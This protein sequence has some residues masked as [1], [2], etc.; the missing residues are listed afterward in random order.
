M[1]TPATPPS[2]DDEAARIGWRALGW[3]VLPPLAVL[4]LQALLPAD[5]EGGALQR[6]EGATLVSD[7]GQALWMASR[8]LVYGLLAVGGAAALLVALVR[9]LGW[10]RA[11]PV[12]LALWVLLW[13]ATGAWLVAGDQNCTQREALPEQPVKVLLAR[14]ILPSKRK[15]PGG[16]EVYFELPGESEPMRLFAQG[17]PPAAF[18]PGSTALLHSEAGRWWGRWGRLR[19]R[20]APPAT[21]AT[22]PASTAPGG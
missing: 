14:E 11:R 18:V 5:V 3:L 6:L 9:R 19:S 1:N 22:P 8:P 12:L 17:L 21:P 15:G 16:T 13:L 2:A 4:V 7:A 20:L 10:A